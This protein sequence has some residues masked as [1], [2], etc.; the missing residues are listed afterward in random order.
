MMKFAILMT[1]GGGAW[2]ALTP[3]R[4]AEVMEEHRRFQAALEAQGKYLA[5]Y[6]LAPRGEARTARRD[7]AGE[8][9]LTDGPFAETKEVIGGLYVIEAESLDEA[10]EWARRSRFIAGSNE[11]RRVL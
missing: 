3:A 11:V 4:Q 5:S 6:Q 9:T 7:A 8:V 10:L 1:D 2:A